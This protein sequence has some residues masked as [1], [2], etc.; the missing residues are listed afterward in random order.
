MCY[1]RFVHVI[2]KTVINQV[3]KMLT[4][5]EIEENQRKMKEM[6]RKKHFGWCLGMA[7]KIDKGEI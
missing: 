3:T 5:A 6:I 1:V 2:I 4:K 7:N